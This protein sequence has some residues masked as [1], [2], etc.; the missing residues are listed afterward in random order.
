M[1]HTLKRLDDLAAYLRADPAVLAVLGLGS[2]GEQTERFDDH[3]DIDFFVIVAD[4]ATKQRYLASIH[5]LS[6]FGGRVSYD[7]V[8]DP[9]G[10]KA[11]FQDGLF[12]EYAIF[13][14]PELKSIPLHGARVVWSRPLFAQHE[15]TAP[16]VP[17]LK[18]MDIHLNEAMTNL[19]VGLH[20]ELR[21]ERLTAMRFIQVY[22]VDQIIALERLNPTTVSFQPDPFEATRRVERASRDRQLPLHDMAPGYSHN[23]RAAQA[24]LNW[25][26][27][28]YEPDPAITT[29][30]QELIDR[31]R[32]VD[33]TGDVSGT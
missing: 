4:Q 24:S 23:A 33:P 31:S 12:L 2:A 26:Q 6:G 32:R 15:T 14:T 30:T 9:N 29:A 25:L 1:H 17:V 27:Q 22:A 13:T 18:T 16:P 8:N 3:S 19:F 21:G 11:L 10:R 5:W 28:F 20:R 7:F